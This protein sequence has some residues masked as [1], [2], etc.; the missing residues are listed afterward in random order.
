MPHCN[1]FELTKIIKTTPEWRHLPVMALTSLSGEEDRKR[2]FEVGIDE[3]QI[4]LD[5]EEVLKSLEAVVLKAR[6]K[7]R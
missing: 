3:Y 2:G 5:R 1:G 4:K 6:G 7:R